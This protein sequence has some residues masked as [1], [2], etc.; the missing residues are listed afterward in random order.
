MNKYRTGQRS[1]IV[2]TAI[3]TLTL[4]A[5]VWGAALV[6]GQPSAQSLGSN[7]LN[8]FTQLERVVQADCE[9]PP[10]RPD[11]DNCGNPLPT[12]TPTPGDD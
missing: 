6:G 5:S 2:R 10:P 8:A 7:A 11:L 9:G 1:R 3:V 12:P 4:G